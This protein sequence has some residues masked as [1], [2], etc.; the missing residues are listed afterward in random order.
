MSSR[1]VIYAAY[2]LSGAA[3]LVYEVAWTRLLGLHL[4]STTAAVS[5]VLASYMGGMALG[6]LAGGRIVS[7]ASPRAALRLYA[8]LEGAVALYAVV[9][10]W[11][12]GAFDPLL[13]AAYAGGS[14]GSAFS[15][16]RVATSLLVVTPPA[17]C[18]GAAFPVATRAVLSS[19]ARAGAEAGGLYAVNTVG[20]A[21]GALAA[22]FLLLPVLGL[23]QTTMVG[24]GLNV[25]AAG[26]AWWLASPQSSWQTRTP[27]AGKSPGAVRTVGG[28]RDGRRAKA[29]GKKV[30]PAFAQATEPAV[31]PRPGVAGVALCISGFVGLCYEVVW[32]RVLVLVIG[33]TSY[34]FS[35]ML[36]AFIGGLALGSIAGSRLATRFRRPVAWL[37]AA[38]LLT[39]AGAA[40]VAPFV[41]RL[42]LWAAEA[43]AASG[44]SLFGIVLGQSALVAA[45]LLPM[46]LALGAML[47]LGIA[48][49]T[50]TVEQGPRD[51][52][53]LYF[54]NTAGAIAGSLVAG[55]ALV[56]RFGL[57]GTVLVAATA[58]LAG[59]LV[60]S[61]VALATRTRAVAFA[62]VALASFV[63]LFAG[64]RWDRDLL[65][66]GAYKYAPYVA[67]LDLVSA[68]K[69]GTL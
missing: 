39:M 52:A 13:A 3:G 45:I 66:A 21:I 38:M 65:A 11:L 29:R 67:H 59:A 24:V 18:M 14:A 50:R 22:G 36:A 1:W 51:V 35:A 55:F 62:A 68:L 63:A 44:A 27:E 37:A 54:V 41:N 10:P 4:G 40:S 30:G 5:T 23:R 8:A 19:A 31:P 53:L 64:P 20:A 28:A 42:P 69:A 32:T 61:F 34:A 58:A 43:A 46:T 56:P 26:A 2:T 25:A 9:L 15:L 6:S 48:V 17:I 12:L 7:G 33:P 47:P 16:V 60:V 57:Q 49:A